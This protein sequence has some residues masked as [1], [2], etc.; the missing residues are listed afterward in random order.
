MTLKELPRK[1]KIFGIGLSRTGTTSLAKALSLLGYKALHFPDDKV[2]QK[3]LYGFFAS[4]SEFVSLSILKAYDA[5][6]DT[7]VCC[8]YKALDRSY[9]GSRFILTVRDKPSWLISC[10]SFWEEVVDFNYH[11]QPNNRLN[12]YIRF[13]HERLYGTQDYEPEAFSRAYDTYMAEVIEYFRDRPQDFLVLDI[14]GGE[15]WS[16]LAPFCGAAIPGASFPFENPS[17]KNREH[18]FVLVQRQ[19][20]PD[21]PGEKPIRGKRGIFSP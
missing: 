14:C 4:Q 17:S 2:T 9:P 11:E 18:Q 19:S 20:G 10:R 5:I 1:N 12:K 8:L 7:P 15:G 6:T 13:I 16:K 3:E 21:R